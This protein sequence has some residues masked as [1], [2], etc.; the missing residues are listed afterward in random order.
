MIS[1]LQ[2]LAAHAANSGE[3]ATPPPW[4]VSKLSLTAPPPL[5]RSCSPPTRRH[6]ST[7][8]LSATTHQSV[9]SCVWWP[10]RLAIA[11]GETLAE[12]RRFFRCAPSRLGS[13]RRVVPP[14]RRVREEE[15]DR[16]EMWTPLMISK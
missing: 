15:E 11:G 14:L 12:R 7:S 8:N 5:C 13:G 3:G 10:S 9:A 1:A 6:G 4:C 2:E 16:R